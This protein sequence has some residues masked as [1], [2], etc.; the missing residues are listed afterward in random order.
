MITSIRTRLKIGGA[1]VLAGSLIAGCSG[2]GG[3]GKTPSGPSSPPSEQPLQLKIF[4]GL[5]NEL[6][7]MKNAYW[8]QWQKLTNTQ[9]EV[10]W[11]PSNDRGAKQD[12]LLASGDLPEIIAADSIPATLAT[13]VRNGAFWDLTPFLGDLSEYP[14]LKNNLPPEWQKYL[15]IDGKIYALPRSRSRIDPGLFIRKDLLDKMNIPV[16]KTV[17]EYRAAL[18]ALVEGD[19]DGNGQK[20]TIGLISISNNVRP[21]LSVAFGAYDPYYDSDGG[22]LPSHLTPMYTDMVAYLH[23]LYVD[24]IIPKEYATLKSSQEEEL[25][26]SGR[27][28]SYLRAMNWKKVFEDAI[29]KTHPNAEIA[30]LA[31][32]GPGGVGVKLQTGVSGGFFISKKVPEEKL[33]QI[34][35]YFDS[36]SSDAL[37]DLAYYGIEGVHHQVKDGQKVL[38][39]LGV[40]EVNTTSKAVGTLQYAKWGKVESTSG[41]KAYNDALKQQVESFDTIGKIDPMSG[42][43]SSTYDQVWPKYSSERETMETKAIVGQ[44]SMDEYKSYIQKIVSDPELKKGFLEL[45]EAYKAM[46]NK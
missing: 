12:L 23:D 27:V 26:K 18:K 14:N 15:T 44:I 3:S 8:T 35:K 9:L 40:K 20:D 37:H 7:D 11:V 25:F 22:L 16:P 43:R 1:V 6:P 32:E 36:T 38:T 24:G 42:L 31:L 28:A 45:A 17:D 33:K 5:Y 29:S 4:S 39:E 41:D 34:L 2:G 30:I 19:P 10:E 21:T 13:A 46:H